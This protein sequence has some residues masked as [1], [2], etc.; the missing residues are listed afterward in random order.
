MSVMLLHT[1]TGL[2]DF[3]EIYV[4]WDFFL[5]FSKSRIP[6][7]EEARTMVAQNM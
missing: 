3:I 7:E 2:L 4:N 5:S 6:A 1:P